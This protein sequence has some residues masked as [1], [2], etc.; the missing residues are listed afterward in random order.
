MELPETLTDEH[1]AIATAFDAEQRR[2][3]PAYLA[4]D[5]A[6]DIAEQITR[7]MQADGISRAELAR[8]MGVNRAYVT[9]LLNAPANM[10]LKTISAA[11]IALALRPAI[12]LCADANREGFRGD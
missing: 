9:K 7:A 3:N 6:L 5:M 1:A 12:S 10:T 2:T 11:A 8:R 4:E